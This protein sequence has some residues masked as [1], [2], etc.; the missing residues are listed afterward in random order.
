MWLS[1]DFVCPLKNKMQYLVFPFNHISVNR[2]E[3]TFTDYF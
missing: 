1:K 2:H 3:L